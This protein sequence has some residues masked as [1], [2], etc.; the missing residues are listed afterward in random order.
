M[1]NKI[2]TSKAWWSWTISYDNL[3]QS[4]NISIVLFSQSSAIFKNIKDNLTIRNLDKNWSIGAIQIDNLNIFVDCFVNF[5]LNGNINDLPKQKI[6]LLELCDKIFNWYD[7]DMVI[8]NKFTLHDTD[9]CYNYREIIWT[10]INAIYISRWLNISK[11]FNFSSIDSSEYIPNHDLYYYKWTTPNIFF[12]RQILSENFRFVDEYCDYFASTFDNWV[13]NGHWYSFSEFWDIYYKRNWNVL[14]ISKQKLDDFLLNLDI[15]KYQI[16]TWEWKIN[17]LSEWN[18]WLYL[19]N[20]IIP[21]HCVDH[22]IKL[23]PINI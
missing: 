15:N 22:I 3:L 16:D 12:K 8:Q 4:S 17:I 21:H 5:V 20:H 10:L 9:F 6:Y 14:A 13:Y 1:K 7:E 2:I 19:F 11:F 23:P 18:V